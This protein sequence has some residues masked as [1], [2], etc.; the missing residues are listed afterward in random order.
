MKK[1]VVGGQLN[2]QAIEKQIKELG[3]SNV[4]V[5]V[6]SDLEAVMAIKNNQADYYVGACETGSGGALAM[7]L[8][9]LGR[10]K[11]V[12]L[13]SPS[14]A[15]STDEIE[16]EVNAGKVAFGFTAPSSANVI[17]ALVPALLNK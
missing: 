13:A 17:K 2:K 10:D 6:K 9:L 4:E 15:M 7:A 3:G 16:A 14:K 11:C 5:S 12:T 8:A 1:I